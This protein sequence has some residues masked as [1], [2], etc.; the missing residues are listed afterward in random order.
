MLLKPHLF[1]LNN[2]GQQENLRRA[3]PFAPKLCLIPRSDCAFRRVK[4]KGRGK[5]ARQAVLMKVRKEALSHETEFRIEDD[6]SANKAGAHKAGVW[7]YARPQNYTGRTL[8]ESLA[9]QELQDGAHL[10]KALSG[11]EGQIWQ[12]GDLQ[13]SRWW[14]DIPD[15]TQ[16]DR[17]IQAS[18]T[19]I[20]PIFHT[21][22]AVQSV[23]FRKDLPLFEFSAERLSKTFSPVNI[24]AIMATAVGCASL[25]LGAQYIHHSL[26]LSA[27]QSDIESI[28]DHTAEI[29]SQRR[30]AL[31]NM[32]AARKTDVIDY[33][34]ALLQGFAD[35]CAPF[36]NTGLSLIS[37]RLRD[38][39]M[40]A[41]FEGEADLSV[42]EI[43]T[44]LEAMPS[45]KD[46]NINLGSRQ[47]IV[48]QAVLVPRPAEIGA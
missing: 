46:V 2:D 38:Q 20:S 36:D 25:Y 5:A 9:R 12:D 41:V 26:T 44:A 11:L 45:L 28:T 37:F 10:I 13:A 29:L 30:R 42:P 39:K 7:S 23:D 8:P 21:R 40:E 19:K 16:W 27:A 43:V 48:V 47:N 4:L 14:G 1:S 17:F 32:A 22:P 15:Q 33:N 6:K 3:A 34:T 18:E 24:G 31:G 35:I